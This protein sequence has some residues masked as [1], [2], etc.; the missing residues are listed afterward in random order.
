MKQRLDTPLLNDRSPGLSATA[1]IILMYL[2]QFPDGA[3]IEDI[4]H[5]TGSKYRWVEATVLRLTHES[6]LRRVGP[7][8]Y[9]IAPADR[10]QTEVHA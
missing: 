8:Q 2:A 5:D 4:A 1:R 3:R 9:A 6:I 7:N 10:G